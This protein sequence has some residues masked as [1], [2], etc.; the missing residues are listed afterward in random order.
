[1]PLGHFTESLIF[2]SLNNS[3]HPL[4][5]K[6][7]WTMALRQSLSRSRHLAGGQ[8]LA[9]QALLGRPTRCITSA[10]LTE[11]AASYEAVVAKPVNNVMMERAF[12]WTSTQ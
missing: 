2:V 8:F 9:L 7:R 11:L 6:L 3:R 12:S 5:S 4:E 10:S 1:M